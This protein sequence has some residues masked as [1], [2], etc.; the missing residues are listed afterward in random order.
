GG[1]SALLP[2]PVRGVT[3]ADKQ[4]AT[5]L[6]LSSGAGIAEVNTVRK[7]LSRVKGGQLGRFFAPATVVSLVLSDVIGDDLAS[8]AS[9]PT[10][11]DPSTF[12]EACAVL[13]RYG[14]LAEMPPSVLAYLRRGRSGKVPE[15]PKRLDNCRHYIIGNSRLALEA[16]TRTAEEK[17]YRARILTAAQQGETTAAARG[18][19]AEIKRGDY[20]RYGALLL[21]GET[22]P[23]LPPHPGKGGR[24]QHYA[25]V[26]LT[27]MR[28]YP[29]R[30]V[31][32]S[33]GTDGSDFLPDVAGA[34]VDQDSLPRAEAQGLD[35]ESYLDRYDSHALLA[36]LGDSLIVTGNTGTNVGDIIVY[37]LDA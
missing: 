8:I 15:T 27:A 37:L 11:P 9:G 32:A 7:H 33:A 6:L 17:G 14:L 28:G 29:G 22:T 31:M 24:N 25:A 36:A 10:Y 26:T 20:D 2:Y 35:V 16:M 12:E 3:L 34:I 30:W 21:G 13:E 23:R 19:A 4:R 18:R 5:E 1:G